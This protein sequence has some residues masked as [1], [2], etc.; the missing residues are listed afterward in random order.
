MYLLLIMLRIGHI[1]IKSLS[2]KRTELKDR[3]DSVG[4]GVALLIKK[5]IPFEEISLDNFNTESIGIRITIG[6]LNLQHPRLHSSRINQAGSDFFNYLDSEDSSLL[7]TNKDSPTFLPSHLPDYGAILD[8]ILIS[9]SLISYF[10]SFESYTALSS[11]HIP[12]SIDL[13]FGQDFKEEIISC[14]DLDKAVLSLTNCIQK[15]IQEATSVIRIREDNSY[16][17]LPKFIRDL[18]K[19]K[20]KARKMFQKSR[21]SQYKTLFNT[22]N[23]KVK[24]EITLFRRDK[25]KDFC[26]SLNTLTPSNSK[27]WKKIKSI[28]SSNKNISIPKIVTKSGNKKMEEKVSLKF[29]NESIPYEQNPKFLGITLDKSLSFYKTY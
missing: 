21:N 16:L 20:N 15:S 22:P 18:I 12:I 13:K 7:I 24:N 28:D 8:L 6:D 26:N 23:N 27:L 10:K 5:T 14:A 2:N 4:G 25:W 29:G 11:D 17:I 19:E 1:N 3:T 9:S